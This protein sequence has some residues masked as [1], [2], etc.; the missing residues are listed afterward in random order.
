M[1]RSK[2]SVVIEKPYVKDPLV[3]ESGSLSL[4]LCLSLNMS[5]L[6]LVE[7]TIE[8]AIKVKEEVTLVFVG[9][10]LD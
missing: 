1:L 6:D 9:G 7:D 3:A 8:E 4:Y 2:I 10:N 5:L